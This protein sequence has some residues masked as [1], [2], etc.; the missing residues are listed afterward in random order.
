ML[1]HRVGFL[2]LSLTLCQSPIVSAADSTPWEACQEQLSVAETD[3]LLAFRSCFETTASA[4]VGE[5]V[6][7]VRELNSARQS[8]GAMSKVDGNYYLVV[9]AD[10]AQEREARSVLE[11]QALQLDNAIRSLTALLEVT[12]RYSGHA[13]QLM[14]WAVNH[15]MITQASPMVVILNEGIER[16]EYDRLLA[17]SRE[18]LSDVRATDVENRCGSAEPLPDDPSGS[19]LAGNSGDES[20]AGF[21]FTY[22]EDEYGHRYENLLLNGEAISACRYENNCSDGSAAGEEVCKRLGHEREVGTGLRSHG[23]VETVNLFREQT[24]PAG[25][26]VLTIVVCR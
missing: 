11:Q 5:L 23:D 10:C 13:D 21:T 12:D 3:G 24:R 8:Y 1:Q 15:S 7:A 4:I 2:V 22:S 19:S 25:S 9:A 16:E 17:S 6:D 14:L 26:A 18:T 20:R